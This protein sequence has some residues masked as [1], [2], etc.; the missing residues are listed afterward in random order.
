MFSLKRPWCQRLI[1]KMW[2]GKKSI[3][4]IKFDDSQDINMHIRKFQED[5]IKYMNDFDMLAKLFSQYS[6]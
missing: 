1:K 3:K 6:W 4:F 5:V 2:N